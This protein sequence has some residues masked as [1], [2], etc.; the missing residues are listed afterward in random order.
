MVPENFNEMIGKGA[1]LCATDKDGK[2]N[3]MTVSWG[4]RGVLWGKDI[5]FVFVRRSRYTYELAE[6]GSIMTLSFFG[7]ERKS[8]LSLCGTKTGRDVDKFQA[9]DLKFDMVEGGVVFK[10]ATKTLILK[11][12]Y[13]DDIKKECFNDTEPLKW[14][15]DGDF[16]KVYACE[17]IK[18][19]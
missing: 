5:C 8:T 13:S 1:L 12:L 19:I 18:E 11:K 14:Y 10:D 3:P 6:N 9:C 2:S 16:H 7:D 15:K 4:A 17:V